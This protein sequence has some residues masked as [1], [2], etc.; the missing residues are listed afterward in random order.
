MFACPFHS[1]GNGLFRPRVDN[2]PIGRLLQSLVVAFHDLLDAHNAWQI[3]VSV[4]QVLRRPP[5]AQIVAH[6]ID[7][8]R[9]AA[10]DVVASSGCAGHP[11][12][13]FVGAIFSHTGQLI[14]VDIVPAQV[15]AC[16]GDPS[17]FT[18][19]VDFALHRSA[20]RVARAGTVDFVLQLVAHI[21]ATGGETFPTFSFTTVV[22]IH[23][24]ET[25]L[26]FG[27]RADQNRYNLQQCNCMKQ[28]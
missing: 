19:F 12:G 17:V 21:R 11:C 5:G 18:A 15:Q 24:L 27:A 20:V 13:H 6:W 4:P 7:Q 23:L 28:Q 9:L 1:I 16:G 22:E 26:R 25:Q 3:R 10:V 14:V 8:F 2:R